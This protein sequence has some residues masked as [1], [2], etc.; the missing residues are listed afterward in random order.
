MSEEHCQW[1]GIGVYQ[2]ICP[3]CFKLILKE[4]ARE[5]ILMKKDRP[6][7]RSL[8]YATWI[9][10]FAMLVWITWQKVYYGC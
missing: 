3:E 8:I 1:C 7:S 6:Y 2:R 5:V 4:Q 9:I 10:M